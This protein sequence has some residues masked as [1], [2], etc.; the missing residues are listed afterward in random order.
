MSS[1]DTIERIEEQPSD[2]PRVDPR[3]KYLERRL[4]EAFDELW[5]DFVDPAEAIYDVDGTAWNRLGG[6]PAGGDARH[7]LRQRA[8]TGPNPRPVPHPGRGQRVRHQRPREP[9]QLHRRQRTRL[10][11]GRRAAAR[12]TPSRWSRDVQAVLDEFIRLNHWHQ[13]QQEIV[14]RK[15]RD[16][17]CFLRLFPAADGTTRVRFVEPA[18]VAAPSDRP[19]D[20]RPASASRP[21]RTTW[22]PCWAIG[23]T[24]GW[25]TPRKSSTARR[26]S[27]PT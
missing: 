22:R 16:G 27:T 26:T 12:P 3:L 6:G 1:T 14:R 9:H 4:T 10:S 23:S 5:N 11:G 7:A 13:R 24:A 15:D 25:W 8:G 19:Q 17:E 21:T 2:G 18:Q 20:P